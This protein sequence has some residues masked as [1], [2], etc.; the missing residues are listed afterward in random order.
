MLSSVCGVLSSAELNDTHLH[1]GLDGVCGV[2]HCVTGSGL[3][4]A[5]SMLEM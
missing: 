3:N 4:E 5:C 2:L 1:T